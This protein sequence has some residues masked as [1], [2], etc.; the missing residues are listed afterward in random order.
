MVLRQGDHLLVA[1]P[2][3]SNRQSQIRRMQANAVKGY[4]YAMGIFKF[5]R[6]NS[7]SIRYASNIV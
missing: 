6:G 4:S 1:M 5:V 3:S 7:I 2:Q